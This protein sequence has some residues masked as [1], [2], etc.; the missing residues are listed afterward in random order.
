M[1]KIKITNNNNNNN[2]LTIYNNNKKRRHF[3]IIIISLC[4][5]LFVYSPAI[6]SEALEGA[7]PIRGTS[8]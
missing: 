3:F 6:D 1:E 4:F 2:N 5:S 8:P 7:K